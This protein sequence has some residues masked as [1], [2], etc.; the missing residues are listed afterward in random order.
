MFETARKAR[1]L[2]SASRAKA[3]FTAAMNEAYWPTLRETR[4]G[5]KA[6]AAA[7]AHLESGAA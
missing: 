6:E 3:A 2:Y 4:D 5:A 7:L 1:A